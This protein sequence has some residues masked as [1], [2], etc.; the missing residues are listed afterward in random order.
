[1]GLSKEAGRVGFVFK[2]N[3]HQNKCTCL[4]H[5][6]KSAFKRDL[7]LIHEH[8]LFLIYSSGCSCEKEQTDTNIGKM[9]PLP[10]ASKEG[11]RTAK[12]RRAAGQRTVP[13][14]R[15][16]CSRWFHSQDQHQIGPGE[17]Q[18]FCLADG[19]ITQKSMTGVDWAGPEG[20]SIRP[21][22][23]SRIIIHTAIKIAPTM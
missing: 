23:A 2:E 17:R 20:G 9:W 10:R 18:Q 6:F 19:D 4:D 5:L 8:A 14:G 7:F 16:A 3:H 22:A 1:M 11:K 15:R 13:A 12:G 21:F